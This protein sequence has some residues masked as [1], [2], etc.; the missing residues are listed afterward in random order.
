[1]A[2]C[3]TS[4][5][6]PLV[7]GQTYRKADIIPNL[8]NA[9]KMVSLYFDPVRDELFFFIKEKD[10]TYCNTY[11]K[12]FFTY[13]NRDGS[14]LKPAEAWKKTKIRHIFFGRDNLQDGTYEYL[15]A[16]LDEKDKWN[17]NSELIEIQYEVYDVDIYKRA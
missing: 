3:K 8:D 14:P 7:K 15:G 4:A 9:E 16:S 2:L 17:A 6:I 1:M 10:E 11:E 13:S 5:R 12:P